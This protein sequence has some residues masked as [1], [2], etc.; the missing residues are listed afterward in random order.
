MES[1]FTW[2]LRWVWSSTSTVSPRLAALMFQRARRPSRKTLQLSPQVDQEGSRSNVDR[3]DFKDALAIL[4]CA[5]L[6]LFLFLFSSFFLFFLCRCQADT[7]FIS[8]SIRSFHPA[9]GYLH[10]GFFW[11]KTPGAILNFMTRLLASSQ[12]AHTQ[13]QSSH[14]H[15]VWQLSPSDSVSKSG[16]SPF[17]PDCTRARAA[18]SPRHALAGIV[19]GLEIVRA[20]EITKC[21]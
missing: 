19:R 11:P 13:S 14:H 17:A 12:P 3:A 10:R 18:R 20:V 1:G 7:C 15:R 2:D 6:A 16:N 21:R 8:F 5:F 4:A 9:L